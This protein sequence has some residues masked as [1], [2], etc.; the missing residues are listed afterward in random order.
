M[1]APRP[2]ESK[3]HYE[4][5]ALAVCLPFCLLFPLQAFQLR[6]DN[7]TFNLRLS[8]FGTRF[9]HEAVTRVGL[10]D[11]FLTAQDF[12][13][14]FVNGIA[15]KQTMHDDTPRLPHAMG[16]SNRLSSAV[17]FHCGSINTTTEAACKLSPTP[18]A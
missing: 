15:R 9:F 13:Q 16:T 17:A 8:R 4:E 7:R 12:Q 11:L 14:S 18:P 3:T 5:A 6:F 2:Y 10:E 1:E